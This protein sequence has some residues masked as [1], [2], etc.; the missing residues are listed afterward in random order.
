M[1]KDYKELMIQYGG[2]IPF[3][4]LG[5]KRVSV[6]RYKKKRKTTRLRRKSSRKR[7]VKTRHKKSLPSP[8]KLSPGTIIR[9]QGHLWKLSSSKKWL[10]I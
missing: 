7:R 6:D 8:T 9:Y 5:G 4:V 10:K 1:N 3:T 2:S